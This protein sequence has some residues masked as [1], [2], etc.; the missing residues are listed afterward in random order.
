MKISR[1]IWI[2]YTFALSRT[3][4]Q[5]FLHHRDQES[6]HPV[7]DQTQM[8]CL[9]AQLLSPMKQGYKCPDPLQREPQTPIKTLTFLPLQLSVG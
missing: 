6:F 9:E 3:P 2:F 5:I 8:K 1:V 7:K 4:S